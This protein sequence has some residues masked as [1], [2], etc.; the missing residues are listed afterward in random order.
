MPD[1]LLVGKYA[2]ELSNVSA[3]ACSRESLNEALEMFQSSCE[4]T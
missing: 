3:Y 2:G 1:W 4:M